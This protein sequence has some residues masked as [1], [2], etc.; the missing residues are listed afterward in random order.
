MRSTQ[1]LMTGKALVAVKIDAVIHRSGTRRER[2]T[3]SAM[4][5]DGCELEASKTFDVGERL[6]IEIDRLGFMDAEVRWCSGGRVGAVF[7]IDCRV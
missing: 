1:D 3:L 7:L 4:S 6:W 5:Y 2:V